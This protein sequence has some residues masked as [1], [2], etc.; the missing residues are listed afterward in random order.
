MPFVLS[1]RT[2]QGMVAVGLRELDARRD[3]ASRE[4]RLVICGG[5]IPGSF[6]PQDPSSP[7]RDMVVVLETSD[8]TCLQWRRGSSRTPVSLSTFLV[9]LPRLYKNSIRSS[10]RGF[11]CKYPET[12]K[13]KHGKSWNNSS[14]PFP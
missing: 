9:R 7:A 1:A 2:T 8:R 14:G 4:Y 10:I 12:A 3:A 5:Q 13:L 6:R 11:F